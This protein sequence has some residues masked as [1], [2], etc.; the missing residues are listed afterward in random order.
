MRERLAFSYLSDS[1]DAEETLTYGELYDNAAAVATTVASTGAPGDRVLVLSTFGPSFVT[2]FFGCLLAGRIP[3]P[4]ASPTGTAGVAALA[5]LAADCA[6]TVALAPAT[7]VTTLRAREPLAGLAWLASDDLSAPRLAEPVMPAGDAVAFLQYTSGS[8]RSPR[9]VVVSHENLSANLDAIGRAFGISADSRGVI[10]LP[11]HH[12]MGLVGGILGGVHAGCPVSLMSPTMFLRDPLTWLRAISDNRATISGGPNFCYDHSVRKV[13][14]AD[15]AG[16]D[17][18]HWEVA[19]V[20]AEPVNPAVLERFAEHVAPAGFRP[21]SFLPCYGM[22]ESTLLVSAGRRGAGV[23]TAGAV[24]SCGTPAGDVAVVGSDGR[25]VAPGDTGEIWVT[26]PSVARGYWHGDDDVFHSTVDGESENYLRTGDLGFLR[27]DELYVTGRTKELIV[28]RGR[29]IAPQD[30]EWSVEASHPSLRAGGC[31][32]VGIVVDGEERLA[33]LLEVDQRKAGRTPTELETSIRQAVSRDHAVD[34]H[35][36]VLLR[37]GQLPRTTSGKIQRLA[38]AAIV[39]PVDVR[40][41]LGRWFA[42]LFGKTVATDAPL[43]SLGMDSVKAAELNTFLERRF[44]HTVSAEQLFNGLTM[45]ELATDLAAGPKSVVSVAEPREPVVARTNAPVQFSLFFFASDA[46]QNSADRYGLFLDCARFADSNGFHAIWTPERHFHRFGGLFPNPSV[47]GAALATATTR[48]RIRAGSVVLPLHDP[49]RTAEEWAMVDNLSHGRVDIAFATGWNADDFVLAPGHYADRQQVFLTGI[50][51]VR[52]LW[53]GESVSLPNGKGEPTELRIFPPPVQPDLPTWITC[54]GGIERFEQAGALGVNVLTAL[55]FQDVDELHTK[56]AAYRKAR[57]AHGHDP[58]AGHVTLMLHTFV[59]PDEDA[60]RAVVETPFK[61]Y[62]RDSVDLWRR[63]SVALDTLSETERATVLDFAFERYFRTSALFGTPERAASQVERLVSA[64][65]NEIACL[66]DFGVAADEVL[67]GLRHL[68]ALGNQWPRQSEPAEDLGAAVRGR[69]A[70][71]RRNSGGVLQKA[72]DFDLAQ[73]LSDADLMPFYPDL[74]ASDGATC[75]HEGRQLIMLGSNNY[76]GLTADHRVREATAKAALAEGP[77]VT[78]SRLMNGS[79]PAH[80]DLERALARFVGRQ[81][82]L[83]FTTGYQANIG[84]LSAFMGEGTALVVDEECHAS[85]YDG[86]AVGGGRLI[87]FRHNDMADLDRRLA[88]DLNGAP[89]MVM[90]DGVY[91]MSGDIAPLKEIRALCDQ[92][93]VPLA[94]DD[95]HGLG[96]IG[97]HGRGVE[98]ELDVDG[99][100]DVLTGTFSKSLASVGGWLAGPKDLM[101][102]VRYYGRSMLFSASIPPPAVAAAASALEILAAEPERVAKI[103]MLAD[104]WRR[105]LA[106]LGYNT[107]TS[108]TAIIPVIIGDELMCLRFAKKLFDAGVYGNCVLAGLARVLFGRKP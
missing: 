21:E 12:D 82:A 34:V 100:A 95:A 25:R 107:G 85:I 15:V 97:A 17:L 26:G 102:W 46:E 70:L 78:G 42:D 37:P 49:V 75:Q 92:H 40:D 10:W 99:C 91:S 104:Y 67:G 1:G 4:V 81:D 108:R 36:V 105:G 8:T 77:S 87:Q 24:V 50:D 61:N 101:D 19:F 5:A 9:G 93:G 65:V 30:V 53:R 89:A 56:L 48:I 3:V 6:A 60:V 52:R 59:G 54:S 76:L 11:P 64:G 51:R 55:L 98:E 80:G 23:R 106:A 29:N 27:D 103:R 66:V 43:T 16:L 20:G 28:I 88:K 41:E 32:A 69:L 63:G 22:A 74:T 86:V 7:I 72:R 84:L 68:A 35:Q 57:A 39:P 14:P 62:L 13:S 58:E 96:M 18:S 79:T 33:V 71:T 83:L 31:A 94:L 90:V 2:A 73:R 47:L 45:A 38:A 44:G